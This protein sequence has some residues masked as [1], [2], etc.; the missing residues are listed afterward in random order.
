MAAA[1]RTLTGLV[2]AQAGADLA[3][4]YHDHQD[5]VVNPNYSPFNGGSRVIIDGRLRAGEVL[6]G[7]HSC[8]GLAVLVGLYLAWLRNVLVLIFAGTGLLSGFFYSAGPVRLA[9]RGPGEIFVGI[10]SGPLI[11]LGG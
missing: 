6:R 9:R 4:D 2:M 7:S 1:G 3:N 11:V 10:N 5:D 8:Y